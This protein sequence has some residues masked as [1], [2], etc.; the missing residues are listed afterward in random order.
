M[1]DDPK[2][3]ES[4]T[5]PSSAPPAEPEDT[6]PASAVKIYKGVA[7]KPTPTTEESSD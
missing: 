7:D 5:P 3:S 6:N 2:P 1:S 4:K